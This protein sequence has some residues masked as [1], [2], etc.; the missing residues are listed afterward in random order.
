M[1]TNAT[2]EPVLVPA[3]PS[4]V[5]TLKPINDAVPDAAGLSGL[6][7]IRGTVTAGGG[8]AARDNSIYTANAPFKF[9]VLDFFIIVTTNVSGKTVTL[10]TATAG[11]GT[12]LS[13]ALSATSAALVRNAAGT[14]TG[15]V[16]SGGSLVLR[17][18]D[19]GIAY[20]YT[21]LIRPET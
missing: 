2:V 14:V 12:A 18:S 21:I 10:R 3:D 17:D 9:R 16:A 6:S 5:A 7:V 13:D 4:G 11:G 15:T 8:G 1:S 19:S 20:E